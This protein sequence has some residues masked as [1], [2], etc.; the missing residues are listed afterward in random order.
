MEDLGS[1]GEA[2]D[3]PGPTALPRV[4]DITDAGDVVLD[5]VF[6]NSKATLKSAKKQQASRLAP[7]QQPAPALKART[8]VGFRVK[9]AVLKQHSK[10]FDR[11]LGDTRFKEAKTIEAAFGAL[12]L[13]KTDPAS[14]H[15]SDLPWVRIVDDDQETRLAHREGAFGDMLRLLHG[16]EVATQSPSLDFV[17]TLA[18]LADRFDCAPAVSKAMASGALK[19]KWPATQRKVT[20][21]EDPR[22]SRALENALRQKILVSWLL[23]QPPRFQAATRELIMNGSLKWSSFPEQDDG[24]DEAM[25]WYLPDGIEQELQ[26]RRECVLNSIASIPRHFFSLYISRTRQCKLGYDSSAACD[27]YQL[28]ETIKFLST[29]NLF[30]LVDFSPSSLNLIADTSLLQVDT[31]LATLRQCPG[32]QIDKHHTNCGLRTRMIPILDFIKALLS[33]SSLPL[34]R[35]SWRNDRKRAAWLPSEED[36]EGITSTDRPFHFTRGMQ[37]DQRLRFEHA[38]G[39]EKFARDV[40][41]ATSW[42][43]ST[44]D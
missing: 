12:S 23:N 39:A 30:F 35:L 10:Y 26:Y 37:S 28:G 9:L 3:P 15:V 5:C 13:R 2:S 44:E 1:N 14:A 21:T 11:M 7:A 29:K 17:A 25:W 16:T 32:Y 19:F 24:R 41:T 34:S 8:R 20:V 38:M 27:S 42:N 6:E 4:V 36:M 40:F 22:M 33:T 18:V 31:I 43:W